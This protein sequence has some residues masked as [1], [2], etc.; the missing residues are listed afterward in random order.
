MEVVPSTEAFGAKSE[1]P[2]EGCGY[3]AAVTHLKARNFMTNVMV[4][5]DMTLSNNTNGHYTNRGTPLHAVCEGRTE[6]AYQA[7]G[8]LC[9][10]TMAP[11][12]GNGGITAWAFGC[13]ETSNHTVAQMAPIGHQIRTSNDLS[14]AYTAYL[15]EHRLGA[16]TSFT[17]IIEKGIEICETSPKEHVTLFIITDG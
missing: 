7:I 1:T 5:F 8:R 14:A 6:T 15:C 17:P 16:P 13:A 11:F 12:I 2:K 10:T 9:M 3:D 4:A